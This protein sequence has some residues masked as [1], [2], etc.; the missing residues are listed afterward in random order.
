MADNRT[1]EEMLQ[2]PMEGYGDAIVVP[3]ILAEN[4]EIKTGLLSLI[5]ANQFHS[6]ESNNPHDHIR[7][8]NRITTK[9]MD[10]PNDA[11]KLMLLPYSLKG[12]AKIWYKKEP[13]WS[14]L[15][16]G[17]LI[18]ETSIRAMQNQIDN[19]KAILKNEIH[20]S[21]QNQINIVKNELRSDIS[22]QTNKLRN[23]MASYFQM[24]TDSSS[25]SGLLPSNTVPNPWAD[26]K[27]IITQS[28]VTLAGPSVSPP[29]SK[30]WPQTQVPIDEPIVAPKPKPTIPYPSR[31]N[32]QKLREKDDI[33][34]LKFVKI[35]KKLHFEL[36]FVDALLRMPKFALMFKSLL[37]NKER[38]FDLATTLVNENCSAVIL[39]KLLEKLGDP[40]MFLIPCDFPEFDECLALVDL[41]ASINL[42]PLS[43]WR[44]LSLLELTSTQMILELADRSMTRPAGIA[45]DVF[46]KV[47]KFHFLTDFVVVDYVVDPRILL[48]LGRPFLRTGRALIDVYGEELTLFVDDEA[49]TF[50]IGQTLKY[51]YNDVE[52]INQIDIIHVACEEYVQEVLGFFD[53]SKSGNLTP[54]SDPIIA[55]SSSSLTPFEGE[56]DICLQKEL[57]NKDPS[58][59][60][61][62]SKELNVEEIKT[63]KSFI[64]EPS[65]L[66]LKELPS[67]LEYAFLEGTDKLPVII[68]KELKDEEKSALLKMLER[69]A[70]NEF[71]CF[72]D[73]FS[74]YFNI[75]IDPQDQEKTTFTCPYGTFA[76]RRMPFGLCNAP[77]TFQ[78]C[79]VAIFHD[80]IEKMME[81]LGMI[82]FRGDSSTL[83]F[84]DF[85]NYHVMNFIVKGMSSQQKKKFFKDVKHYFWDDPY[86]FK[87]CADKVIRRCVHGQEAVDILTACHNGPTAGHHGANFTAKTS[88]ILVF[89][90]L[91]LTEMPMTWSHGVTL[92]NVKA[93]YRNVMKCLK[94][95]FKFARFSTFGESI[96]WDHF[97]LLKETNIFS[98]SLT[99]C[100]NSGQVEVLN[101]GLKRILERTIGENRASWSDKLD[102][103][104][105]AFRTAFKTP[106][107]CTPYKL[108]YGKA[109]HLPIE[110]EH[111]AYWALKHCN[112]DLKTAG[113]HQKVQLNELDELRDQA[114]ENAL[115]YRERTKK[116]H[117]S[118]IKDRVFNVGDRVILFNSRLKIFSGKLKTR[119]T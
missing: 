40:G 96:S 30:E 63:I 41:G 105:W 113:D 108:V 16:W 117:D 95:Q 38:L 13:P 110:L 98:W 32:K 84:A 5:Q 88:L 82:A 17:D 89:I 81:T 83:W 10:V 45:E 36:S 114:Y 61:L 18:T 93:K 48:I 42:M 59:S 97:R 86:L 99:S 57:L 100:P 7:S 80:M 78:R 23:M 39:K 92:V 116:I 33:L 6:F 1:M 50:N 103:A 34:A 44:K 70:E 12:A 112:F 106:I 8:F 101:R 68:S 52:S 56:G 60:P 49:I 75:S 53:N 87:I 43:I 55:L 24:N 26:L 22:N 118:M 115:I 25:G 2:A 94:M 72:L 65:E 47:G 19:F 29:P 111:K 62:P 20:S 35:F 64:D 31:A 79:M 71:Y 119:W 77:G 91:L 54:T 14:I 66:E 11:I 67:H 107:G 28:G 76:Y 37:N 74:G 9:F 21:M 73:E 46:V 27:A 58:S 102:D 4:F 69:L 51:S 3:D 15:T 90:G 85:A 109:C 104:L